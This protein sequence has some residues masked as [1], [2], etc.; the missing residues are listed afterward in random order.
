MD[1]R[2][3]VV[4]GNYPLLID[5]VIMTL[6]AAAVALSIGVVLAPPAARCG[7]PPA[8]RSTVPS[9]ATCCSFVRRPKWC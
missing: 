9:A 1:L 7:S 3:S 2:M 5:G 6:W 8:P 4:L